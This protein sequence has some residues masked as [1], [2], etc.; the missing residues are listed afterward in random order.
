MFSF[1]NFV[2]INCFHSTYPSQ[3]N[4]ICAQNSRNMPRTAWSLII[5]EIFLSHVRHGWKTWKVIL[6]NNGESN[7]CTIKRRVIVSLLAVKS[8]GKSSEKKNSCSI[9]HVVCR[10]CRRCG[11]LPP[12]L[13]TSAPLWS[14]VQSPLY[15]SAEHFLSW[16]WEWLEITTVSKRVG[17]C[18]TLPYLEK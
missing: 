16:I 9:S 5:M 17:S 1:V 15:S 13:P 14:W 8:Y 12:P 2:F 11:A 18:S 7:C 4:A 3:K 6:A 10:K